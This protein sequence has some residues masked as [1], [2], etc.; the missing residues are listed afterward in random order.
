MVMSG[1]TVRGENG[2]EILNKNDENNGRDDPAHG[3]TVVVCYDGE[4]VQGGNADFMLR[5]RKSP[6]DFFRKVTRQIRN[7][8]HEIRKNYCQKD[9]RKKHS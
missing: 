5:L 6:E 3:K 7:P 9:A 1:L 2:C 4:L 8:N